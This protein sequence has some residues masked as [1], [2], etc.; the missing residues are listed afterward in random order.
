MQNLDASEPLSKKGASTVQELENS[1]NE[2]RS[3]CAAYDNA[4]ATARTSSPPPMANRV[5]RDQA[6]QSSKDMVI[7]V[8]RPEMAPPGTSQADPSSMPSTKRSV[9][10]GQMVKEGDA[11]CRAGDREPAAA[12]GQRPRALR[13]Q[14]RSAS[15]CGSRSPRI[16]VTF[17]GKVARI[18]PSV[19]AGQP[20]VSGRDSGPQR[21]A[22]AA[23]RRVR[24]GV[25][26]HRLRSEAAVVPIESVSGSPA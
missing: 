26:R 10:E 13:R 25:D 22:A 1:E 12:L 4:K 16:P 14:V 8:P 5:A 24:Q 9:S 17:E 23:A 18:N 3:A 19:D 15:P 21:T 2:Y 6:E 20:D 7:H 11:V